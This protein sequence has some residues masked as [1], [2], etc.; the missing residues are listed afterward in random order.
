MRTKIRAIRQLWHKPVLS[1]AKGRM[2]G[3]LLLIGLLT[4]GCTRGPRNFL[5]ENDELRRNNLQLRKQVD[6]L[7][8][9]VTLRVAEIE[10]L[11]QQLERHPAKVEGANVPEVVTLRFDRYSGA[12]DT[13]SDGADDHIRVYLKTLDQ[14]GR[15]IPVAGRALLQAVVINADATAQVLAQKTFEPTELDATFRTSITGTHYTL[16]LPLPAP[17]QSQVDHV[18]VKLSFTDAATGTELTHETA[19][20]LTPIPQTNAER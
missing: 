13:D 19:M 6:Q 20:S 11:Q 4:I 16:D 8:E 1:T 3:T 5:N 2:S 15:F 12:I 17:L 10:K 14:H 18:T 7:Q 9:K